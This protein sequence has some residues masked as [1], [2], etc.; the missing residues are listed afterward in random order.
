LPKLAVADRVELGDRFVRV[1][2]TRA[3]YKVHLGSANIQV[4]PDDRYLCIVPASN[5]R[6]KRVLLPFEGDQVLTVVLSKVLLL[7]ADDKITDPTILQQIERR[8]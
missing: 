1:H 2:G 8:T 7:A 5:G 6:T 4:E 3:T